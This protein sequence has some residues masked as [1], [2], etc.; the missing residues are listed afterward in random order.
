M[1]PT[2]NRAFVPTAAM[3]TGDFT[4]FASP[5]C[6]AG[7]QRNSAAP[8]VGNR[9]DPAH[10]S[11]AALKITSRLPTTNDPC[12]LVQYGLPSET[13]EW[14][15]VAKVDFT[16]SDKH[17][18]FGR[19]IATSQ[20]TPPPFSLEAAEQNLLVT[21]IGGRDNLAQT[22]TL[23]E[24]Y[25]INS[26][27]LNAV[28]FA[29]NNTDIH[30]TS[31]DFFSAPDV[32]INIYS[33]MP[34]YMLLT[35]DQRLPA[36]RRHGKPVHVH[37]AS[38]ADQRRPDAGARR[39]SVRIRREPTRSWKSLSLANV[40]SPGQLTIDGRD[41][42]ASG[43]P[44]SCSAG[45][46]RTASSRRH[47]TRSTW[48][49]VAGPLR[50]GHVARGSARDVQL[51]SALGAVL[52]AAARERRRLSVRHGAVH[53]GHEE[54]RVPEWTGRS[55]FPGRPGFPSQAGMLTD[56]NNFGPRVGTGLG[57]DRLGPHLAARRLR[58]GR[59]SS[60][61]RSSTSTRRWRRRG[62]RKFV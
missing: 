3:L 31:T 26:S 33:Y 7:V 28:R 62:A 55:V 61:T 57:S 56:W 44:T 32:G 47:R 30:R 15:Q 22:F 17:S 45:S 39:P 1:N 38:V 12:G 11:P 58:H 34:N 53:C 9:V 8:F 2:D 29:Y 50:A 35:V 49:Q 51:R 20:F 24:N 60:S 21:R 37:H 40:R 4:A 54:H 25:V 41:R 59:M 36:W 14:Q 16:M 43:S 6:N 18:L 5:A 19:Y 23:G 27:T 42:P 13:D 10:F 48:K 52:P 46:A